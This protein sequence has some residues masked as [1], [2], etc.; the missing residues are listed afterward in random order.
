MP[1]IKRKPKNHVA[2]LDPIWLLAVRPRKGQHPTK[3]LIDARRF[4]GAPV[5]TGDPSKARIWTDSSGP[6]QFF[7]AHPELRKRFVSWRHDGPIARHTP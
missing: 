6:R 5:E 1:N 3:F 4:P 7:R 2:G